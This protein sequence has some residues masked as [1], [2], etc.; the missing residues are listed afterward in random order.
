[1]L[2]LRDGGGEDQQEAGVP[3]ELPVQQEEE[4]VGAD[5]EIPCPGEEAPLVQVPVGA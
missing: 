5:Q 4:P 1:M 3:E 2:L